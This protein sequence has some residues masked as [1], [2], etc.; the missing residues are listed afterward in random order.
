[1]ILWLG[2]GKWQSFC[3][4]AVSMLRSQSYSDHHHINHPFNIFV[5]TLLNT[6]LSTL[7]DTLLDSLLSNPLIT[8]LSAPLN[9]LT[10]AIGRVR[11]LQAL[12]KASSSASSSA[13]QLALKENRKLIHSQSISCLSSG[14]SSNSSASSCLPL[15]V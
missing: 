9:T 4:R 8:P 13:L 11:P 1:M 10:D 3:R 12:R 14:R 6:P 5:H 2:I 7:L 15:L